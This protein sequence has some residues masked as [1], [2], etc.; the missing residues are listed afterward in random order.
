[1]EPVTLTT[2]HLLLR[3]PGPADTDATHAACQD[4]DIQRWTA[5]PSPYLRDHAASFLGQD[6][7]DG[8]RND[9]AFSFAAFLREEPSA[10][11]AM[12]GVTRRE[13][14][15]AEIGFWAV[16]EHRGRGHVVETVRTLARWAFTEAGVCR[17]EWRA[18]A[19]NL[20]SRAVAEKAGFTMEGTLRAAIV[21]RGTLRDCWVASLLPS[22]LGLAPAFAYLPARD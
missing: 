11:V 12:A 15:T 1:M 9:T 10:L 22:D 17:L 6:V 8:W 20:A 18:E 2:D 14:A 19:G 4:P 13:G 7:P 16:K 21:H 3:P 5:V